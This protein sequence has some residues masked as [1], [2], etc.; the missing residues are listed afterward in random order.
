MSFFVMHSDHRFTSHPPFNSPFCTPSGPS[1]PPN[2]LQRLLLHFFRPLDS[3]QLL[4]TKLAPG[5]K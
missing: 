5:D 4:F 1:I 2:V 3:S